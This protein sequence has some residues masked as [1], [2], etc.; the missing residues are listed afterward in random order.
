MVG[1]KA[2][3]VT[4]VAPND[5]KIYTLHI[6]N[7]HIAIYL[8][9]ITNYLWQKFVSKSDV[10]F[11]EG[12]LYDNNSF[13]LSSTLYFYAINVSHKHWNPLWKSSIIEWKNCGV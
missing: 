11:K 12:L 7:I 8:L 5:T 3:I 4:S 1:G 6:Y 10:I 2:G 13:Y 9:V